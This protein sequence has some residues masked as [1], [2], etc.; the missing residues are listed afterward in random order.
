MLK[1]KKMKFAALMLAAGL[2]GSILAGCA[3]SSSNNQTSTKTPQVLRY[4]LGADPKTI[5][6]G[7]N[8]SV[9]GGTVA[10]NNFEGLTSID[11]NEKVVPGVA[12]KWDVSS[13]GLKYTF[14]L[15][16]N[17]KWSDGKAVTAKDFEYAWKRALDPKTASPYSY[18]L[19][20]LLNG[21][22]YNESALKDAEKTPGV[23]TATADEVGVKATDDYTL[24]VTLQSSTPYFLSL[25]AFPTYMPVRK[26]IVDAHPTDW[27]T[28][29]ETYI[30]NG[31]FQLKD[32]KA[33]DKMTFVKNANYWNKDSVKLDT[34]EFSLLDQESSYMS[35]FNSNQIDYIEAPPSEQI[36]TLVKNG[37][38]KILPYLGTYYYSYNVSPDAAKINPAAAKVLSNVKVR[39]AISFAIDR[40]TLVNDITKGGQQPATSFVPKGIMDADGKD[41]K[42]K[43]YYSATA[44][45]EKAKQLLADAGYPNGQGIPELEIE[46][47]NGQG[48]QDIAT[49]IQ[50]MLKKIGVNVKLKSV[51]RKVQLAD[52]T[53][54][55]YSAIAR[56]GWIA[57]YADPMTFLD[58]WTSKSGNNV[59]GYANADYDKLIA[60]AKSEGDAAKRM[61]LLH[62]A[63]DILIG[64]MPIIPLYEYTNVVCVKPYVKDVHKSPLGMVYFNQTYIQK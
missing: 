50:D 63:E 19:Y 57:D 27:A 59:A 46:Y 35:A 21:Q 7:V 61:T 62:Q 17:A 31:P 15:R 34:L 58:M 42:K 22:G 6:P 5:D 2:A 16:K 48:H 26:D 8:D 14:H 3:K 1:S 56:N 23:K 4:N 51:E 28:K 11:I 13:D 29:G 47:N 38:A 39:Q 40:T 43:D 54:H 10:V 24:D 30:G 64:D 44:D 52:T 36:P 55:K 60:Q 41:F 33:K 18:Q 32:W 20:Y 12:E 45:V 25:T 37:T 49:A 9:E 53:D